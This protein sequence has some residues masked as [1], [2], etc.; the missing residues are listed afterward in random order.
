MVA[1]GVLCSARSALFAQE[2]IEAEAT[3]RAH[4]ADRANQQLDSIEEQWRQA[5]RE[6]RQRE[7]SFGDTIAAWEASLDAAEPGDPEV[8]RVFDEVNAA[9]GMAFSE[10]EAA[11]SRLG[12][13]SQIDSADRLLRTER[14]ASRGMLADQNEPEPVAEV[15]QQ[16]R[17]R[18]RQLR[19]LEWDFRWEAAERVGVRAGRLFDLRVRSLGELSQDRRKESLRTSEFLEG[20]RLELRALRLWIWGAFETRRH[21]VLELATR[22]NLTSF[23][24]LASIL[25]RLAL[26]LV[27]WIW[28]RTWLPSLIERTR[29]RA[30]IV[31]DPRGRRSR[32]A[33][34]ELLSR[35][36]PGLVTLTGLFALRWALGARAGLTVRL[37]LLCAL[38]WAA[39][40]VTIATVVGGLEALMIHRR[41]RPT[42]ELRA[43]LLGSVRWLARVA[44]SV[45]L[46]QFFVGMRL[47]GGLLYRT[48]SFVGSVAIGLTLFGI[49]LAWRRELIGLFAE[50]HPGHALVSWASR[51]SP[52]LRA[53]VLSPFLAIWA[54]V[55][56][57]MLL[58]R[59]VVLLFEEARRASAFVSRRRLA[60][61]ALA[62]GS[63]EP[64]LELPSA[65]HE[66]LHESLDATDWPEAELPP[67]VAEVRDR[68]RSW[69]ENRVVAGGYVLVGPPGGGKRAW[70]D[71]LE[72]QVSPPVSRVRLSRRV[73]SAQELAAALGSELALE[74]EENPSIETVAAQ[75]NRNGPLVVVLERLENLFLSQIGGYVGFDALDTLIQK[76]TNAVFWISCCSEAAFNHLSSVRREALLFSSDR[77]PAWSEEQIGRLIER[78]VVDAG[79]RLDFSELVTR[80]AGTEQRRARL[81]E[82]AREAYFRLLWDHAEG[83]PTIALHFFRHSIGVAPDSRVRVKMFA[84]PDPAALEDLDEG[85]LIALARLRVH[86][87]LTPEELN[88]TT[89]VGHVAACLG[90]D[91][92]HQLGVAEIEQ[93]ETERYRITTRWQ[94]TVLRLLRRRNLA[95]S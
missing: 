25:A 39:Y 49:G 61:D 2:P 84:I 9:L 11:L 53:A 40:R 70:L 55:R 34:S 3:A 54:L 82:D 45:F 33:R 75:L 14:P 6:H 94:A 7:L 42:P 32:Q 67:G 64:E 88:L 18:V 44:A 1:A 47:E 35:V 95:R 78:R 73:A 36:I 31:M 68:I 69:N 56:G 21:E 41:L 5:D 26:V 38:V 17:K 90:L 83:N 28:L 93:G 60:H 27:G 30:P 80:K 76:T 71:A 20:L 79:Y 50:E 59:D 19:A 62:K 15:L 46:V 51:R 37:L 65:L 22:G 77:L 91:R 23:G 10:F 52:G 48:V 4:A 89:G 85:I 74:R 12:Q 86:G 92:L 43:K 29:Q 87:A 72:P 16:I 24:T 66:A 63:A 8:D 57:A 13:P 81:E 58:L